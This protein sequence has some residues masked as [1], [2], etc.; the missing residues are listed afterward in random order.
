MLYDY[1]T[2]YHGQYHDIFWKEVKALNR[3]SMPL[4]CTIEGGAGADNI[5]EKWRQHYSALFNCVK[6]DPFNIGSIPNS[7][8]I[9]VTAGEVL[10]AISQLADN[11]A[12]GPDNITAEHLKHAS[13]RVAVLLSI[14][15]T[16]LMSHGLLPDSMLSVT[17]VPVIKDKA[18]KVGSMDNYRPIA[19]A[20]IL[21]K[22]IE[23][24]LLDR[25]SSYITTADNQF[26]F[27]AKHG[28]DLCIYALKKVIDMYQGKNSS[29]LV[30]F[31]DASKA[32][33]KVQCSRLYFIVTSFVQEHR[34]K[35]YLK[36]I[37]NGVVMVDFT[38]GCMLKIAL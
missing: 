32:F 29:V 2:V 25:L 19:L 36:R 3:G 1:D 30:G 31:I 4:P 17:L 24:I 28:T 15:F 26:G 27:K 16:G 18:G 6:S 9:G 37:L 10:Q 5:A 20:S 33:D 21:S 12:S 23:R 13:P 22:V 11:K 38:F 8:A 7:E 35:T 34:S 14:C